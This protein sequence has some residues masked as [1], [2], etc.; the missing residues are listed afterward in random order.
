MTGPE[1]LSTFAD[2]GKS[3]DNMAALLLMESCY[4][5]KKDNCSGTQCDNLAA[6]LS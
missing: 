1:D 2:T 6:G 4:R 5:K 3:L